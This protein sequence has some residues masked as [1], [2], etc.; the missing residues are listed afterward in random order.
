MKSAFII[1]TYGN[2]NIHNCINSIRQFYK[3][4]RICIID[5]NMGSNSMTF[6]D[7]N[8]H[9]YRNGGNYWELGV[10][11]FATKHITDID[12]FIIIHNSFILIQE[13]PLR[14]F[15][16]EYVP[17]W[18]ANVCDY[19]PTIGWVEE[20][21]NKIN[22]NVQYNKTWNSICGCCCSINRNILQQ[23]IE[24]NCD[25]IY[26]TNKIHAVGTEILLGYL[27]HEYLNIKSK[28]LHDFTL[29]TYVTKKAPWIWIIKV[30]SNQGSAQFI[31]LP[32][33]HIPNHMFNGVIISNPN[34]KN[35]ILID[36]IKFI[37]I[38][39][40]YDLEEL[41]IKSFPHPISCANIH[42][43]SIIGT[44]RH[45]LFTKKYFF[46]HF[47][48]QFNKVCNKTLDVFN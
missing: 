31:G 15:N 10:I 47:N 48:D 12:K 4:I 3:D 46:D 26:A 32:N 17:L 9:Y 35:D 5:N 37:I 39:K 13:L 38:D 30:L 33:I 40:K 25:T 1:I 41:L 11:W 24:K 16:E 8:I 20:S 14:I 7:N 34:N 29:N 45:Q 28:P 19:S 6:D 22:I 43:N 36:V 18:T 27:I 44:I 23:L 21:L 2:T 42:I